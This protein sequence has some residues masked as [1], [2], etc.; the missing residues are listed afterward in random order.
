MTSG[1]YRVRLPEE[2]ALLTVAWL[3]GTGR[4]HSRAALTEELAPQA[5]R[6]R[7]LPTP[8]EPDPTP[9]DVVWR[10]TAGEAT[11]T[12]RARKPNERVEAMREALEIWNP[13]ADALLD[14]WLQTVVDGRVAAHYP[15]GWRARGHALLDRYYTPRADLQARREAPP[16]PGEP[17]DPAD[18]ADPRGPRAAPTQ[19]AR[20][21]PA[22]RRLDAGQAR[23]ARL[24]RACRAARRRGADRRPADAPRARA[25]RRPADGGAAVRPRHRVHG[26]RAR[27]DRGGHC[28]PEAIRAAVERA[29]AGTPRR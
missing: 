2:A 20:P 16:P 18:R 12:L 19:V 6:L 23:R 10:R 5:E 28:D 27:P 15:E 21:A 24:P 17:R 4:A 3:G 8:A 14:H 22:C 25:G 11:T 1:A 7:F 29:L 9:A 13:F 26:R